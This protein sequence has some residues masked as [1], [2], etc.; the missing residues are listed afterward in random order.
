M[1]FLSFIIKN[2][3]RR[4]IRTTLTVSGLAVAV[5]AVVALVGIATGFEKSFLDLYRGHGVHLVVVRVGAVDPLTGHLDQSIGEKI[6]QIG[7]EGIADVSSVLLEQVSFEEKGLMAVM[8]QGREPRRGMVYEAKMVA[9]SSITKSP[10][11]GHVVMLGEVIAGNLGI[12][13]D[14]AKKQY[15]SIFDQPFEVIGVFRTHNV[16]EDGAMIVPLA[17]LQEVTERTDQ[18]TMFNVR[19]Q[20]P[21]DDVQREEIIRRINEIKL[22]N[23]GKQYLSA[24]STDDFVKQDAKIKIAQAMAWMTSAIALVIG[25]I[26]MLNTMVMSVFERTREIGILRAIGW[27]KARVVRMILGEA[28]LLSIA[29]AILGSIGAVVVT[30]LL[31]RLPNASQMVGNHIDFLVIA[32][33][34]VIALT[35]GLLGAA[36][37]AYR[38]A[39]L[40]PTSALRHEE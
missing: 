28:L 17:S 13:F 30:R 11:K 20:N 4:R 23:D 19:L 31:T 3:S 12:Q 16:F 33:G 9:G 24:K 8:V 38:G 2:V 40:L 6:K 14:P 27:R 35:I 26:G 22:S 5:G 36:Y 7:G 21:T 18:V 29:G 39:T 1:R 10:E 32:Q 25:A 15:V 37:P 34:C